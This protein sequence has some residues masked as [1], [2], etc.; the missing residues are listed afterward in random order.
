MVSK[1]LWLSPSLRWNNSTVKP[2]EAGAA[3]PAPHAPLLASLIAE[4]LNA[5][6]LQKLI[7]VV[8]TPELPLDA[9]SVE[10]RQHSRTT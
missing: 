2:S 10:I 5:Y 8:T 3:A 6:R 9:N 7:S 1:V 4:M